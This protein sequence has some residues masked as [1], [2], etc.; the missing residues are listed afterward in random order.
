MIPKHWHAIAQMHKEQL[1]QLHKELTSKFT[2]NKIM[3][4]LSFIN[5]NL[6]FLIDLRLITHDHLAILLSIK[7]CNPTLF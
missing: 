2:H 7:T 4:A 5:V 3:I 6:K 1:Q